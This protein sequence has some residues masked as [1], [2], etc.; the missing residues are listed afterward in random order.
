[1]NLGRWLADNYNLVV[2]LTGATALG[3]VGGLVGCFA[4]LRRRA[5]TGDAL[6]HGALP[7]LCLAFLLVGGRST[8]A[9]LAGALVSGVCGVALI[10]ALCRWTRIK[11][12]AAIGLVL[13]V[14]YGLGIVL[15]S[16]TEASAGLES[17]ILGK[18]ANMTVGDV[19]AVGLFAALV[20]ILVV[21][22][23]KELRL[24]SFDT[25]FAA[26]QGWPVFFLDFLLMVLISAT[27]VMGL[28][29]AGVLMTAALL[30]I[31]AAAARFW[32]NRLGVM[33]ALAAVCGGVSGG[34][35]AWL[36]ALVNRFPTGPS[37]ILVAAL[38]FVV[39]L[40]AAPERGLLGQWQR[41]RRN[42]LDLRQRQFLATLYEIVEPTL[43]APPA[44][45]AAELAM[46]RAWPEREI[47]ARLLQAVRRRELVRAGD[48][49]ALT[50]EGLEHA[51]AEARNQRLWKLYLREHP[52]MA[53]ALLTLDLPPLENF[54]PHDV[55]ERLKRQLDTPPQRAV[56]PGEATP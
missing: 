45:S 20:L 17:F 6:A 16:K 38:F 37:I 11:E 48:T 8:P 13:S 36:S 40:L 32:T 26:A 30:I 39:S 18:P 29:T 22:L 15:L 31:P 28:P 19:R 49:Y 41:R 33:L 27:V 5:L 10:T 1:M 51:A 4:V 35:G 43:P 53:P 55:L 12:D 7:G 46:R 52:E 3:I 21:L 44:F 34:T 56:V 2:V 50:T 25:G 23:Y 47:R 42:R 24:I 54:L 9:F 14:F